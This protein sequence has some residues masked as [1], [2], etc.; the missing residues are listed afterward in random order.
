MVIEGKLI[1]VMDTVQTTETFKK[2]SFVVELIDNPMYPQKVQFEAN[3]DRVSL[4]DNFAVGDQI[5]V[6]FNL[7]GREWT[8]PQ[9]EKKYF[10]TLEAWR[11]SKVEASASSPAANGSEPA[12]G[13]ED[14]AGDTSDDL[15][16]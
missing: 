11:I 7:R 14:M 15:P 12:Y 6:V 3:Q 13:G 1:V 16:F 9:G 8:S 4:L 2:R 10:N 5:E